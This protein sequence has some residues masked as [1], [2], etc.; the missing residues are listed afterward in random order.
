MPPPSA[1]LELLMQF[2][3]PCKFSG[4]H[5]PNFLMETKIPSEFRSNG[6]RMTII[7]PA[8][9]EISA[10]KPTVS[11]PQLCRGMRLK[12]NH[13]GSSKMNSLSLVARGSVVTVHG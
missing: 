4:A 3:T 2:L 10:A 1:I 5:L 7:H 8:S 6:T 13:Y 12:N 9:V 11:A